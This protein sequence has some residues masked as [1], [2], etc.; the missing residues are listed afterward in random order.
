M[1]PLEVY[2]HDPDIMAMPEYLR[3]IHAIRRQIV[4]E[5]TGLPED[6]QIEHSNEN[7]HNL[8][9]KY[10]INVRYAR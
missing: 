2:L 5:T 7:V 6:R 9:T 8:L 10:G 4:E 3:E 1:K